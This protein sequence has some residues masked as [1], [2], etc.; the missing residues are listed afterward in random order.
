MNRD[1]NYHL[2]KASYFDT[3][4]RVNGYKPKN[5][6]YEYEYVKLEPA[7]T[8]INIQKQI[9]PQY[10]RY[11][12]PITRHYYK[13]DKIF[14]DDTDMVQGTN[15]IPKNPDVWYP[16][17][18][19]SYQFMKDPET[20]QIYRINK[21]YDKN[22]NYYYTHKPL[23]YQPEKKIGTSYYQPIYREPNFN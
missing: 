3:I 17:N 4:A 19:L 10:K 13:T 9:K 6:D 2:Q 12:D 15:V 20:G 21:I 16:E 11:F 5:D 22:G 7:G 1:P 18:K 8:P 14:E 23:Y